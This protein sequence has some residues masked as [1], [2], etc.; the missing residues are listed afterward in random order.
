MKTNILIVF[1]TVIFSSMLLIACN[2]DDGDTT[3]PVIDLIAPGEGAAFEIG[4]E[5]G[6]HLDMELSDNEML[7]S[8]QVEIHSN[9]NGHQHS[10]T[11]K[12]EE[13]TKAFFF[14]NSWDISG[15]KNVKI[16]HHEIIIPANATPGNYHLMVYCTDVAGNESYVARNIVLSSEEQAHEHSYQ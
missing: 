3:P 2:D 14:K 16:H 8:Y 1:F 13:G 11:A 10:T 4:D 5:H 7:Q 9:F 6:V 12:S 15:K